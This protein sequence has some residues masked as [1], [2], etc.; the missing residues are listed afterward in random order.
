MLSS[1][2]DRQENTKA[3]DYAHNKNT[4]MECRNN[5]NSTQTQHE[6]NT[7]WRTEWN[8]LKKQGTTKANTRSRRKRKT[9]DRRWFRSYSSVLSG[10]KSRKK[11]KKKERG[12][13][14]IWRG[15]VTARR[16]RRPLSSF[17]RIK[18]QTS[19]I[20]SSAQGTSCRR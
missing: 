4:I 5:G 14:K 18:T 2:A 20:L 6:I 8:T 1:V 11:Q 7:E 12:S 3:T 10:E 15:C 17:D 9:Q 19:T 16:R 13:E